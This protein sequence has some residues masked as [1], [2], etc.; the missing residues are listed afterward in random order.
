MSGLRS[1]W[2]ILQN[3]RPIHLSHR[4]R[5]RAQKAYERQF[6]KFTLIVQERWQFLL[7]L[8]GKYRF[9]AG[10]WFQEQRTSLYMLVRF[11]RTIVGPV[12]LAML[13]V[14]SLDVLERVLLSPGGSFWRFALSLGFVHQLK[15]LL[16]QFGVTPSRLQLDNS[17]Y[18]TLLLACP[19]RCPR[20]F[21]PGKGWQSVSAN[22]RA[23]VHRSCANARHPRTGISD[24]HSEPLPAHSP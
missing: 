8:F 6:S 15:L 12:F 20:A 24:W 9:E 18:V 11:I 5:S 22:C 3:Y 13:L 23:F 4:K 19:G 21:S 17:S 14:V 7:F 1:M 2:N 16:N 10:G